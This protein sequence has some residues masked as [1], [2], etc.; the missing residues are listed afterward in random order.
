[1]KNHFIDFL[2]GITIIFV[3]YGHCLQYGSGSSFLEQGLYWENEIM[4]V[5]YSFHMPLFIG[6]SGYLFSFSFSKHGARRSLLRR[7][8]VFL[9]ICA[10]WAIILLVCDSVRGIHLTF[11]SVVKQILKY[12]LTDFWF[13]WAVIICVCLVILVETFFRKYARKNYRIVYLILFLI[14][15]ITPDSYWFNAHKFMF[16]YFVSGFYYA[17]INEKWIQKKTIGFT[18]LAI[19]GILLQF[20]SMDTYIYTTG[21]TVIGKNS[22]SKQIIIDMYRYAVGFAGMISVVFVL[23]AVYQ[24]LIHSKNEFAAWIRRLIEYLGRSSLV[25]YILST[26]LFVYI[27]PIMTSQLSVNYLVTLLETFIVIFVCHIVNI[28][29]RKTPWISKCL[30]GI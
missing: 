4:K 27:M 15:F 16:P 26:Y 13:L 29:L 3:I 5:I 1:M 8:K 11:A 10:S 21:I 28:L 9:P 23:K 7:A 22:I 12:F 24:W 2:K 18:A 25:Y 30:I 14:F 19:W 6:I 17:N 20:Y